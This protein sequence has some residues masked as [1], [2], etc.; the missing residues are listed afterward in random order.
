MVCIKLQP[1]WAKGYGRKAAAQ[2]GMK[3]YAAAAETAKAGLRFAP[4]D[5]ALQ[6]AL[7]SA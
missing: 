7:A 1:R 5:V 6:Q 3:D 4:D 2:S